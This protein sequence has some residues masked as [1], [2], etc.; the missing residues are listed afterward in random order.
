MEGTW[1]PASCPGAP[2][3]R[4]QVQP[5]VGVLRQGRCG[6]SRRGPE[7]QPRGRQQQAGLGL[8]GA[9]H[10]LSCTH[11]WVSEGGGDREALPA[12]LK[13]RRG[14]RQGS[15]LQGGRG[16]HG[17]TTE[18]ASCLWRGH[19]R[20]GNS[21]RHQRLPEVQRG[22][23]VKVVTLALGLTSASGREEGEEDPIP[24]QRPLPLIFLPGQRGA[25][26]APSI[27]PLL[28]QKQP[29]PPK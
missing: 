29:A 9:T 25:L 16:P 17:A 13:G 7:D 11:R 22:Q 1:R 3:P 5:E 10:C 20:L 26:P 27:P 12:Q 28:L 24:S 14:H 18:G 2:P 15:G 8:S 6:R 23:S 4:T 21:S 19:S